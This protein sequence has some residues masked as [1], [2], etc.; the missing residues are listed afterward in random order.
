MA[1]VANATL[2]MKFEE[3]DDLGR[4]FGKRYILNTAT[5]EKTATTKKKGKNAEEVDTCYDIARGKTVLGNV[6]PTR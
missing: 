4:N 6:D 5:E 2:F 3:G 1:R